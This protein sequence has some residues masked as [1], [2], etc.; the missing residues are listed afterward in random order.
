MFTSAF[1]FIYTYRQMK[2][3]IFLSLGSNIGN[4]MG[5]IEIT[6]S[7]LQSSC[8]IYIKKISSFYKTSPIGPKQ[9]SFYNIVA[10]AKTNLSPDNLLHLLKETQE[11]IGRVKTLHWGPRIIDIDILFF[12]NDIV[13][14]Q[15]LTIPHKEIQ[16]R[17][18]VLVPL[19]EIARDFIHPILKQ[20]ICDILNEK[21]LTL[22]CQKV[23]ILR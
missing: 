10:S 16:N 12:N 13:K 23:K 2:N 8:F 6:L 4:R 11:V 17:L 7:F 21:L 1:R 14:K 5:N 18:F 3:K 15:F 19:A 20:K 9:R 22:R